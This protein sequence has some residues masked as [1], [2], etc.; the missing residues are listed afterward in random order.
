M[1]DGVVRYRI[2]WKGY[3]PN[4][5]T[6]S[7]FKSFTLICS[8][9]EPEECLVNCEDELRD[10]LRRR[11]VGKMNEDVDKIISV[12]EDPECRDS[13]YIIVRLLEFNLFQ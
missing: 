9:W 7:C 13:V 4:E 5:D 3:P 11:K 6:L 1:Q 10:F 2:R 8:S 12:K